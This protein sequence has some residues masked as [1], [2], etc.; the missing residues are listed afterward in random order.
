MSATVSPS[1]PEISVVIATYNRTA[2]VARLLALLAEQ[3]CPVGCFEVIVVDDG[4]APPAAPVL[5]ALALPFPLVVV[6]QANGGPAVARHAGIV[7]ARGEIL[8]IL[9][10]DMRVAPEFLAAHR[11]GHPPDTRRVVLGAVRAPRGRTLRLFERLQLAR[12]D[13]LARAAKRG[14]PPRGMDLYTGNVSLRR[15]D[16]FA[17]GGFDLSLR[18]SEDAEL[19]LRLEQA[20]VA[21]VTSEDALAVHDSDHASLAGWFRRSVAYGASEG[22]IAT[23]HGMAQEVNPWR[24]LRLVNPV[25]R[26]LLLASALAPSAL[27][28]LAWTAMSTAM[29]LGALGLERAA[30]AGAMFVY[31]LL[32]MAGVGQQAGSR[33]RALHELAEYLR[34]CDGPE[35]G[36]A[37]RLGKLA[38]D[39]RADHA[40]L[41]RADDKYQ[42]SQASPRRHGLLGNLFRRVGFQM[43]AAYRVMRMLRDV[44]LRFLAMVASR[45][46]RHVYGADLHW[47]AELAPGVIIV[48]GNGL[49]ISH[50]ARVGPGCILFQHVTLGESVDP[51]TR[52]Q[53]APT[54]EG[55]VHVG[56][57]ATLLGPITVGRGT[58]VAAGTALMHSVPPGSLVESPAPVVRSRAAVRRSAT[59][60]QETPV[61]PGATHRSDAGE[62]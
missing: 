1:T 28:P 18:L 22:R 11:A 24:Y 27:R 29:A 30:C 60:V 31:G 36:W 43:L 61:G 25:S 48:H 14:T 9:D 49:V 8:V 34:G 45:L 17:V 47:D 12:M 21:F 51:E 23:Q 20:G 15:A 59:G 38:A 4:S 46:I 32:Y 62:A 35:L 58:K 55:D 44:G 57:G 26:P 2:S 6:S 13:H 41:L 19:G 40:A 3:T 56:P 54:L 16:Y 37:M 53:G 39:V 52:R 42:S 7:R 5:E 10:D 50:A 33:R